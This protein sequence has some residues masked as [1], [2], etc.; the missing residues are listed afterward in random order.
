MP[1]NYTTQPS[2]PISILTTLNEAADREAGIVF[3]ELKVE[4]SAHS[5][6]ESIQPSAVPT[7][8]ESGNGESDKGNNLPW[9]SSPIRELAMG[10]L[11][12][13]SS[14]NDSDSEEGRVTQEASTA[15]SDFLDDDES[16]SPRPR[17]R[18]AQASEDDSIDVATC[19]PKKRQRL[20]QEIEDLEKGPMVR[21][22]TET[23]ARSIQ[24]TE[25]SRDS[26]PSPIAR[27]DISSTHES[28]SGLTM[29]AFQDAQYD[30]GHAAVVDQSFDDDISELDTS[31]PQALG[32]DVDAMVPVSFQRPQLPTEHSSLASRQQ[33]DSQQGWKATG[34]TSRISSDEIEAGD[35]HAGKSIEV[36][37][38]R[39]GSR[40][41]DESS[42]TPRNAC[43]GVGHD[44]AQDLRI[45]NTFRQRPQL[46][47]M[48]GANS[49]RT[50]QRRGGGVVVDHQSARRDLG[51]SS[52]HMPLTLSGASRAESEQT[53]GDGGGSKRRSSMTKSGCSSEEKRRRYPG[54]VTLQDM[55]LSESS[56]QLRSSTTSPGLDAPSRSPSPNGMRKSAAGM[57][58]GDRGF[59]E[60]MATSY[61]RRREVFDDGRSPED[62]QSADD[63]VH[64]PFGLV[65]GK[66][67]R[68]AE[69]GKLGLADP[70]RGR[71]DRT[72][73]A[74]SESARKTVYEEFVDAYP[75]YLAGLDAF[76][77][78]CAYVEW[79]CGEQRMEHRS[80]WDDFVF[81]HAMDY[82]AWWQDRAQAG[83]TY[84]PYETYYR[85]EVDEPVCTRRILSSKNLR[86]ALA[87]NAAVA[88]EMRYNTIPRLQAAGQRCGTTEEMRT[89][90]SDDGWP[91]VKPLSFPRL[92]S[93]ARKSSSPQ[94]FSTSGLGGGGRGY[95]LP[96]P[97]VPSPDLRG[98]EN[99]SK[100]DARGSSD[101][102]ADYGQTSRVLT[103]RSDISPPLSARPLHRQAPTVPVRPARTKVSEPTDWWQDRNTPFKAF[104]K[105]YASL[106]SVEGGMGHVDGDGVLRLPPK[107]VDVL[108]W[109]F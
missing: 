82:Q 32:D 50:K 29:S 16:I 76:V 39:A 93:S 14:G 33:V 35:G 95:G 48:L 64:T 83:Q 46:S 91:S 49:S 27:S 87:L 105:A 55:P 109:S 36:M 90:R 79:L 53:N 2:I 68:S 15:A 22:S 31:L 51:S 26:K 75:G 89:P 52:P 28:G 11:P 102:D 56:W 59:F 1:G 3:E 97:W 37:T 45:D 38:P 7:E 104:S 99:T 106:R 43:F 58:L 72:P 21:T 42:E 70:F 10:E 107:Q 100:G 47:S 54:K 17:T 63:P 44:G 67:R 98:A 108:R 19:H 18:R 20:S 74:M 13:D 73:T 23:E 65:K 88:G 60:P 61:H 92:V 8:P 30:L 78:T 69:P 81:R 94:A 84:V 77:A 41:S 5:T 101:G 40:T 25:T 57:D 85:D 4:R 9:G 12:P 103:S 71:P 6:A 24:A 80:L 86:T 96:V 66:R 34:S 62:G